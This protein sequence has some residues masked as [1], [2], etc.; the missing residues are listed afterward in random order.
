MGK[1]TKLQSAKRQ[2]SYQSRTV[3]SFFEKLR[4]R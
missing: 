3:L 2:N 1:K 4:R